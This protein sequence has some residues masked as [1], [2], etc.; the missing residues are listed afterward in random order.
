MK[1]T[2]RVTVQQ[3]DQLSKPPKSNTDQTPSPD[4]NVST[5]SSSSGATGGVHHKIIINELIA[6]AVFYR[7]SGTIADLHKLLISFYLPTEIKESKSIL[8]TEF[9][10]HL[11]N[12]KFMTD[13]RQSSTRSAH[14]AEVEDILGM[15][16][17]LDDLNVLDNIKFTAAALDRLPQYGPNEINVCAVA[18]KQ[19]KLDQDLI[20]L[21]N[22]LDET[23]AGRSVLTCNA[24]DDHLKSVDVAVKEQVQSFTAICNALND[25]MKA[26]GVTMKEQMQSF[27]TTCTNLVE[28][29]RS[30]APERSTDNN[31]QI[32]R[33]MNVV[34]TGISENR[35]AA[36]WRDTVTRALNHAAGT[37]VDLI[38]AFRLGRYNSDRT[39]PIL[40]KLNSVW[41]RRL[42]IAGARKLRDVPEFYRVFVTADEP[43]DIRRRNT[44][45]RLK[46]RAE[47]DGKLVA[48]RDGVLSVDGVDTFSLQRGFIAMQGSIHNH[49]GEQR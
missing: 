48:L 43:L 33:T 46:S 31:T 7:D 4:G 20:C 29:L 15:I 47:R 21:N 37:C 44:L 2:E 6:Y 27:T 41:N 49:N 19:K 13:R 12:C 32:D 5:R 40:V 45:Q 3:T 14:D 24:L 1:K 35:D 42:V 16:E 39:R 34:L 11:A 10:S 28:S 22:K 23:L 30:Q 25:D 38:D 8:S 9:C 26:V 17:I 36:V 18:D